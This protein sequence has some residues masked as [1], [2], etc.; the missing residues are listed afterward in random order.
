MSKIRVEPAQPKSGRKMIIK[1]EYFFKNRV[2]PRKRVGPAQL[3][4]M[5]KK[6]AEP[7]QPAVLK[8][9]MG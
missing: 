9:K 2:E 1:W 7:A 3:E 8:K 5:E 4:F 6:M